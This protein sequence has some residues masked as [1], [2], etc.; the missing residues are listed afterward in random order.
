MI[1]VSSAIERNCVSA[2]CCRVTGGVVARRLCVNDQRAKGENDD[3]MQASNVASV[4][5][6]C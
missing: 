3:E 5:P 2:A 6:R 1:V 4:T